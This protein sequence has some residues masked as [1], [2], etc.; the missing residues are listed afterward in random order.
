MCICV[1]ENRTF[2]STWLWVDSYMHQT[3]QRQQIHFFLSLLSCHL[4]TN[5][6]KWKT[7]SLC[8][9]AENWKFHFCLKFQINPP[10]FRFESMRIE[11]IIQFDC[12]ICCIVYVNIHK[13]LL[14]IFLFLLK[15]LFSSCFINIS[16][17]NPLNEQNGRMMFCCICNSM[18]SKK[19]DDLTTQ[20]ESCVQWTMHIVHRKMKIHW[21]HID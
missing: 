21:K 8:K 12:S 3:A 13:F 17:Q 4:K 1:M 6:M 2:T 10:L 7:N 15:F 5:Q 9:F 18:C 16:N 11:Y 20:D 14:Y 19:N